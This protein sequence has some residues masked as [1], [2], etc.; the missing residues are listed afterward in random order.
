MLRRLQRHGLSENITTLTPRRCTEN[1]RQVTSTNNGLERIFCPYI[2][3]DLRSVRLWGDLLS[4][5]SSVEEGK[6]AMRL[7]QL[8]E[9]Y[10]NCLGPAI[11]DHLKG[12]KKTHLKEK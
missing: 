9:V 7:C 6:K 4:L 11:W 8:K 1:H 3:C 5:S 12:G 2:V 10:Q